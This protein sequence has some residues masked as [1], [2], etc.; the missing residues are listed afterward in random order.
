M[1]GGAEVLLSQCNADLFVYLRSNRGAADQRAGD[2]YGMSMAR[3][4][5]IL[6]FVPPTPFNPSIR[7]KFKLFSISSSP[8]NSCLPILLLVTERSAH[9]ISSA[10][11]SG[12]RDF[13]LFIQ[14]K[15]ENLH[16]L[17][18]VLL[19]SPL[20][21]FLLEL[22]C[23]MSSDE[24]E[25]EAKAAESE[26]TDTTPNIIRSEEEEKPQQQRTIQS[27]LVGWDGDNDPLDPRTFSPRRKWFYVIV[28]ST[29][30]MLV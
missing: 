19:L 5:I 22:F 14:D 2:G 28:V 25:R 6:S 7:I 29:G 11:R 12:F 17:Y 21:L 10:Y 4:S 23:T 20:H 15:T 1:S 18:S 9:S 24:S 26:S 8:R 13:N 30:S 16:K 27:L 3:L